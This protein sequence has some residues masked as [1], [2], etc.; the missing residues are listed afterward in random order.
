MSER[1]GQLFVCG[2]D[3]TEVNENIRFLIHEKR[4]AGVIIFRRNIASRVQLKQLTA[5]LQREAKRAG[6]TKPLLITLDEECGT[7]SRLEG[8]IPP[9]PGAMLQ[10]ATGDEQLIYDI[11]YALAAELRELGINWNLAPV[12]DI[13]N[14]AQNPVIGVRSFGEQP[15]QV[16]ALA[17]QA[18]KGQQQNGVIATLKHFPGHGDTAVDSHVGLPVIPHD[19][20]RLH[21]VELEPFKQGIAE[22]V[23]CIMAAHIHFPQFD[24]D[25]LPASISPKVIQ[26]LLRDQ[27]GFKGSVIT[28]CMEMHAI[29]DSFGTAEACIRAV[30]AGVDFLLVSHTFTVQCEAI[31]AVE[32]AII[33]GRITEA[34][35]QQAVARIEQTAERA[36]QPYT[37]NSGHCQ[38]AVQ[39][40]EQGVTLLNARPQKWRIPL[41]I[42]LIGADNKTI[43]EDAVSLPYTISK[44]TA[45][46]LQWLTVEEAIALQQPCI[47]IT[48]NAMDSAAHREQMQLLEQTAMDFAVIAVKKPYDAALTTRPVICTYEPSVQALQ[49]AFAQLLHDQPSTG[50]LPVTI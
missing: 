20:A 9:F 8:L 44:A 16:G 49:V 5:D 1:A 41:R 43:A 45:E 18:V 30:Q 11:H 39:A 7:V 38:L 46:P 29:M 31:E 4:I 32:Q 12:A 35:L 27:L 15:K 37:M 24:E 2:F 14:N 19:E 33:Q 47:V 22:N 21:A 28:D 36:K 23:D 25:I 3:G 50:R 26:G 13:Q 40:F 42:V 10:A 6:Y 17:V 34:Q 48:Q